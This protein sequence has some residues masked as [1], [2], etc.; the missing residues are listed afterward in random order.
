MTKGQKFKNQ[1]SDDTDLELNNRRLTETCE[2]LERRSADIQKLF[3]N[4][5]AMLA[6]VR[7]PDQVYTMA[8]PGF[9]R[10]YEG[11]ELVGKTIREAWPEAHT[12]GYFEKIDRVFTTGIAFSGFEIPR[13]WDRLGEGCVEDGYLNLIYQ[14]LLNESNSVT[15]VIIFG[16]D[17]TEQVRAK[18]AAEKSGHDFKLLADSIPHLVWVISADGKDSYFNKKWRTY[19][20]QEERTTTAWEDI[21]HAE[22]IPESKKAWEESLRTGEPY[23]VEYRIKGPDGVYRWHLTRGVPHKDSSGKI[24]KWYGTCTDIQH[25]RDVQEKLRELQQRTEAVIQD[26]PFLLWAVDSKGTFTFYDGKAAKI[27][28][29]KTEDRIGKNILELYKDRPEVA[30]NVRRALAGE[31]VT[32]E[33]KIGETWLENKFS[34]QRDVD[35]NINGVVGLSLD[36]TEKKRVDHALQET[37]NQFQVLANSMPQLAWMGH[38]DGSNYWYNQ[39]WYS[40]T[41]TKPGEM[42]GSRWVSL[43]DPAILPLV[44]EKWAEA[45]HTKTEFEMEFPLKGSDGLFKW[46]ITRVTPV[47]NERGEVTKWFGTATDI[48]EQKTLLNS[49]N[50]QKDRLQR[51][52]SASFI[53]VAFSNQ[54]GTVLEANDAFLKL[55]GYSREDLAAGA[56]C[57]KVQSPAEL[58]GDSRSALEAFQKFGKCQPFEK[59]LPRK[60]GTVVPVLMGFTDLGTERLDIVTWVMDLTKLKN[61]EQEKLLLEQSEKAAI[62]ASKMKSEFLANMSH[63]IRT[64]INGVIGMTSLLLDT[65]LNSEQ[66]DYSEAVL[67]S[68]NALLFLVN[69][70]LDLSKAEAGKVDLEVTNF[71]LGQVFL[72]IERTLGFGAKKKGLKLLKSIGTDLPAYLKGDPTRL[73]QIFLNLVSNSIKF[74][75]E[76][77][78]T[79]EAIRKS[80]ENNRVCIRFEVTDTGIGIPSEAMNRMFKSFSQ[81]DSSTTRKFGGSGLGLSICKHLVE[82]MGGEIGVNSSLDNGSTFWFEIPF[83]VGSELLGTASEGEVRFEKGARK[84]RILVAEDNSVNQIIAIK[85]LQKLGHTAIAVGNGSEAIDALRDA[86]YDLVFM[87]CQMPELDGY[88]A[89]KLIRKSRTLTCKDIPIIAMTANAMR[90]DREKCLSAGMNDYLSKP[91]K[92][93]DLEKAIEQNFKSTFKTASRNSIP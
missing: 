23:S 37:E 54:L 31:T 14:P 62:D 73:R 27:L 63:E 58:T 39:G 26:A 38:P 42:D 6:V 29:I 24:V 74:T 33:A 21:I 56:I 84:L 28:G 7:A 30:G 78:V 86:P 68:A 16:V 77:Q 85:M 81:A 82:L 67:T 41:G 15:E 25:H 61:T 93:S 19:T 43:H 71:D 89:T 51:L 32:D 3:E 5:P 49:V 76:G 53:G 45:L 2:R 40:Y 18:Q 44:L 9:R 36:I 57:R 72:D 88:E 65:E 79:I 52:V 50:I 87:D 59:N 69:D 22:D 48:D 17:V 92:L 12:S 11:K 13:A 70:I 35:G 55:T 60:D 20:G 46:F 83:E 4:M 64:P 34:P 75:N 91:M 90:G 10:M 66:R 1:Q 8:N 80:Q 47:R